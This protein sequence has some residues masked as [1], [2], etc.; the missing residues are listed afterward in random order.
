MSKLTDK[1]GAI[2]VLAERLGCKELNAVEKDGRMYISAI[3]PTQYIC[4]QIWDKTKEID[5][6]LDDNDLTLDLKVERQDIFGEYEVRP[7]DTLSGIA[8][9]L[10]N[11][12]LSYMQIFEANRHILKDPNLI[13]VGQKLIIPKF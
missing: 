8:K 6:E 4:N 2:Y 9:K 5:P 7:G 10:S 12:K 1:Y 11:G 3:C 13:K